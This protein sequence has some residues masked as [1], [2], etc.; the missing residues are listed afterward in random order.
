MSGALNI[1]IR[2][3]DIET[4]V[5]I[6]K[7]IPELTNP[8]DAQEYYR[9]MRERDALILVAYFEEAPAGFKVGYD[10]FNDGS[11]YSWM[12][13][14]IPKFRNHHVAKNLAEYQEEW[15]AS[16]GYRS[17]RFKTRN[18]HKA[19]LLFALSNGFAIIGLEQREGIDE[20]RITLEKILRSG[21]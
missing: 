8:H 1:Q 13:G 20:H 2:E 9:R 11:F 7:C 17:I 6:S 10:K 4:A 14:V 16:R 3:T 21:H 5:S 15:A 19:M 18:K 12:G